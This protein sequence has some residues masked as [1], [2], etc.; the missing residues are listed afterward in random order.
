MA[1][2]ITHGWDTSGLSDDPSS[3]VSVDEANNHT[4]S[5]TLDVT[6]GGTGAS[7]AA[8]ARTNLGLA[9]G[10]DVARQ[11]TISAGSSKIT[12][13][14]GDGA[15]GNPTV[16][17]SPAAILVGAG[18]TASR[19]VV[20]AANGAIEAS[21]VT[22]TELGR[23]TGVTADVQPQLDAKQATVNANTS[24]S[25]GNLTLAGPSNNSLAAFD[26]AKKLSSV[27]IGSGLAYDAPNKTLSAS[28]GGGGV[29]LANNTLAGRYAGSAGAAE[30]VTIGGRLIISA[31]ALDVVANPSFVG[32]TI[33]DGSNSSIFESVFNAI[34]LHT[35]PGGP[36]HAAFICYTIGFESYASAGTLGTVTGKFA[37]YDQNG[38]LVGYAPVYDS[39]T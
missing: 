30:N 14:N 34:H 37:V 26:E 8:N 3:R 33:T 9:I 38:T 18:L 23:L 7:T 36:S 27:T 13:T 16:D 5:G 17:A 12:V 25:A 4:L 24:L 20:S 11:R 29:T 2:N 28:G 19:A 31:G 6:N 39:I 10:T 15:S 21:S 35:V 32:V 22:A 1:I